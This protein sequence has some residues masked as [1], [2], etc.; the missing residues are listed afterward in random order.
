MERFATPRS[1]S[2]YPGESK[3]EK[4]SQPIS[5]VVDACIAAFPS[6]AGSVAEI[7]E[8]T[9]LPATTD[10]ATILL[11]L[12]MVADPKKS[13]LTSEQLVVF[14]NYIHRRYRTYLW[15]GLKYGTP[16]FFSP[17]L[18]PIFAA[19]FIIYTPDLSAYDA[20]I[21]SCIFSIAGVLFGQV[22]GW[23][24]TGTQ[25]NASSEA[26]N[27]CQNT[28]LDLSDDYAS[29]AYFLLDLY[30]SMEGTLRKFAI[31]VARTVDMDLLTKCMFVHIPRPDPK[32]PED[33]IL[34]YARFARVLGPLSEVTRFIN[35]DGTLMPM[36]EILRGRIEVAQ[37]RAQVLALAHRGVPTPSH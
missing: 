4:V 33:P 16:S 37:L 27:H 11:Y 26:A 24:I 6:I 36:D 35:S 18:L 8:Y 9:S 7:R 12:C 31:E 23:I 2:D 3:R 21:I 17:L 25:P 19:L 32:E 15:L 20:A 1:Y 13:V 29:L 30:V 10:R 14:S 22:S 5:G 34:S 28:L